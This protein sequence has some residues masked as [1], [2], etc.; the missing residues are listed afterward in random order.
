MTESKFTKAIECKHCFNTAPMRIGAEL[1]KVEKIA[2]NAAPFDYDA[3]YIW[4]IL[5][6]PACSE[7]MLRKNYWH[8]EIDYSAEEEIVYPRFFD[9]P[10]GLP[11]KIEKAYE[12]AQKVKSI[13]SNAFAVLLGRVLDLVCLDKNACGDSL[14]KRLQDIAQ[15]GIMPE[16]LASMA[17]QLRQLRNIGA[18]ADLGELNRS[19]IPILESLSKAILEYVYSAPTLMASVQEKLTAIKASNA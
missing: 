14:H 10:I 18:H 11:I 3:G 4:E 8:S 15:K 9:K 2:D 12:A 7:V 19:E 5:E 17:H 1:N 16:Q 13:D 6:C